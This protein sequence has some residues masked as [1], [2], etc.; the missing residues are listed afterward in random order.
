MLRAVVINI[1]C[2][3]QSIFARVPLHFLHFQA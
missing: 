2:S 1:D 3:N